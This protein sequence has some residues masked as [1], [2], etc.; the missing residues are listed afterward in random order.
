MD[1]V[2]TDLGVGMDGIIGDGTVLILGDMVGDG[3][4]VFTT[5][6][7]DHHTTVLII[8]VMVMVMDIAIPM[9]TIEEAYHTIPEEEVHLLTETLF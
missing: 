9:V 7:G 6:T 4:I 8:L 1:G 5:L 3:T 2:G